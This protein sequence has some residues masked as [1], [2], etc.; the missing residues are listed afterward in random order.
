MA[1]MSLVVKSDSITIKT[2]EWGWKSLNVDGKQYDAINAEVTTHNGSMVFVANYSPGSEAVNQSPMILS[3][4]DPE[5]GECWVALVAFQSDGSGGCT[6]RGSIQYLK[7]CQMGIAGKDTLLF[8][9]N[10]LG[11]TFLKE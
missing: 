6:V 10:G 4:K 5:T 3:D 8:S 9:A 1:S 7:K 2:D 11:G